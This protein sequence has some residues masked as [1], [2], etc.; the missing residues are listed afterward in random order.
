[1]ADATYD[2]TLATDLDKIRFLIQDTDVSTGNY[3]FKD[4]E[5]NGMLAIWVSY[6]S[7]A[8]ACCEILAIKYANMSEE[9][10]IGSLRLAYANRAQK[11]K[12]LAEMLRQQVLK[13]VK[14]YCGGISDSD[15]TD[16]QTDSDAVQPAF[17]RGMMKE[18]L[19]IIDYND[20]TQ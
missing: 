19:P 17:K 1:M 3:A 11:Y 16:Y 4:A 14:P 5:I 12:M 7:C 15:K 9:K 2:P 18:K 10:E 6:K 20:Q 13:F 8:I